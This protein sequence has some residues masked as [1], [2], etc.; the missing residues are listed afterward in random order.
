MII[1]LDTSAIVKRYFQEPYSEEILSKWQSA[2]QIITSF[3]AY[4]E[5]MASILI[6]KRE[7]ELSTRLV[8]TILQQ[9]QNDWESFTRVEVNNELNGYVDRVVAR[10]PLRGFDAIHLASAIIVQERLPENLLF[11]CFDNRLNA[12]AQREGLRIFPD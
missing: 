3:V 10:H 4:A 6:K 12:A 8:R 5:T 1:Y 7:E 9:F 2:T 11:I